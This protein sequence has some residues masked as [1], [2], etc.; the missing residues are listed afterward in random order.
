MLFHSEIYRRSVIILVDHNYPCRI[1]VWT[2][3]RWFKRWTEKFGAMRS[4]VLTQMSAK[5]LPA[6]KFA[7]G[8]G[9]WLF[10][11]CKSAGKWVLRV[12]VHGRR[13]EMG[14]GRWPDVSIA[15]AREKAEFARRQCRDGK[16]PIFERVRIKSE[17]KMFTLKEAINA[18][19]EAR[20]AELKKDGEA[21]RWMSPL[22][23]HVIPKI[24][25]YPV[26]EVDQHVICETLNPIWHK[27][28]DAAEKALNRINLSIKHAAALGI[29]VDMQAA[30]KAR[31]L[32]GRQRKEVVH[33]PSLE[34]SEA[35]AFYKWLK[36]QKLISALALRYLMLT[37]ARTTEV[38]LSEFD[39]IVDH[40]WLLPGSR[41]KNGL[42]RRIPLVDEAQDIV[43]ACRER[44]SGDVLFPAHM[45]QPISDAAM[46]T[47]MKREG[48]TARPHG[49]RATFR[50]W[51]E[52]QTDAAFE[53]KEACLGHVVDTGV[54]GAY[55]RSDRFEKRLALLQQ[56]EAFLL[57][58]CG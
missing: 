46:S 14:L 22:T 13:R 25:A 2:T 18:C 16:D 7:D 43:S 33:I 17:V 29:A 37:I 21:G 42:P 9:L 4:H 41:T 11:R 49:F 40:V 26:E 28:P 35:P 20:K 39:E 50:T 58:G 52:E 38:R 32:M 51:V 15:D 19:F 56:W 53:V 54:V 34:Y 30:M 23:V 45:G 57:N 31:A 10:K 5:N 6:G 55:Q 36:G 24:G 48:Y 3:K 8:R 47:F 12:V 27:K 44:T 1:T